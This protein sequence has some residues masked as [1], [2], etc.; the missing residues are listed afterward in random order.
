VATEAVFG[1]FW[2]SQATKWSVGQASCNHEVAPMRLQRTILT[3]N[4]TFALPHRGWQ[5][6]KGDQAGHSQ[7]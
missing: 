7:P 5:L 4:I 3:S 2:S 6:G 1:W